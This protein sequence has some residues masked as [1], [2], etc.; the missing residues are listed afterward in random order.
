MLKDLAGDKAERPRQHRGEHNCVE[1]ARVVG[2]DN[3]GSWRDALAAKHTDCR[4]SKAGQQP[5]GTLGHPPAGPMFGRAQDRRNHSGSSCAIAQLPWPP[6]R[7][8]PPLSMLL[9]YSRF[10]DN[11]E[12]SPMGTVDAASANG[13]R[14]RSS[15]RQ[16]VC[17]S[18]GGHAPLLRPKLFSR[19]AQWPYRFPAYHPRFRL[20]ANRSRS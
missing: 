12:H 5:D 3:G 19:R 15:A 16:S 8:H 7:L 17:R 10:H 13:Y 18:T 2:N 14:D 11:R 4:P 6:G 1:P 20:S 9:P